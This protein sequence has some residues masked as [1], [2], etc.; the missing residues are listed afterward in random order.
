VT[1]DIREIVL[2]SV[3]TISAPE[4]GIVM[5][6]R[7]SGGRDDARGEAGFCAA[8]GSPA[9]DG[10]VRVKVVVARLMRRTEC[11]EGSR[12]PL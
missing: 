12:S 10:A 7:V 11:Y 9:A 4:G 8:D 1:E 5:P 6:G 3:L 2:L